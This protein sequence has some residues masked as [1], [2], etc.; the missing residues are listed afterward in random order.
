M[1]RSV[2][3][4]LLLGSSAVAFFAVVGAASAQQT[5]GQAPA[6]PGATSIPQITVTAP[7]RTPARPAPR[8][9]VTR[10]APA[11]PAPT[12]TPEQ[13]QAE[14]NRQVVQRTQRL[15]QRRDDVLQPKVGTNI[16]TVI[17]DNVPQGSNIAISDL[18]YQLPGVSQDSTSAGDFHV[19]NDH[20]NVQFRINGIQMPDG[21]R[22][23]V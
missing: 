12:P 14:A 7:K 5:S 17:P 21:R 16:S 19:R 13:V 15:D 9:V 4:E 2:R 8:P 22:H 23:C 3:N 1:F 10:A 11:A 6:A 18:V 20:A